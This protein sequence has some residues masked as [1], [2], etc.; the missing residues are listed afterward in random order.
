MESVVINKNTDKISKNSSKPATINREKTIP[1][2]V[3]IVLVT[4]F[5]AAFVRELPRRHKG[6]TAS[7]I[8]SSHPVLKNTCAK[9]LYPSL[10]FST[11]S[12]IPSSKNA[13]HPRHILV[14]AINLTFNSVNISQTHIMGLLTRQ[15]LNPQERN[16]L[17]DCLEMLDQTQYELQQA[18][19]LQD[20][21]YF[22]SASVGFHGRLYSNLKTLLSAAMTNENTCIDGFS[23]VEEA[24]PESQKGLKE[25]LHG[26]LAPIYRMISNC[27]A[28]VKLIESISRDDMVSTQKIQYPE[29]HPD[30]FPKWMTASDRKLT[31]VA[32]QIRPNLI[33]ATDGSGDY[34]TIGE[35]VRMAPRMSRSRFMIKIKTGVYKEN[36]EIPRS[37]TNIMLIGEGMNSTVISG[38]RNFVDGFS[39]FNSATLTVIGDRFLARDLT[40]INTSSREK[41]QAVALRVASNSA[42]YRC[43]F[44]SYQDTLYAHSF[45][46]LYRECTIQ[47]TIDFIFGNAA[48]IFQNCL[49]LV[50]KPIPGQKNMITA[51][52][53]DDPNQNTGISLQNC[54]IMAA[55]ELRSSYLGELI[56][57]QG[58]YQWDEYSRLDTVEYVEYMNTGPGSDTRRRVTWSGYKSNCSEEI[59]RRFTVGEFLHG[60]DDWLRSTGFPFFYG[61]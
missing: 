22:S 7:A 56:H 46:Q 52:G 41:R 38:S 48:A 59:V 44:I 1:L 17:Q 28:M 36:V 54:T 25:H 12:S 34:R 16:A 4:L 40:I 8:P 30:V 31:D 11:L 42:F 43:N 53:R 19:A 23:D 29:M 3:F 32:A 37:K 10:C 55:P 39:T 18:Q 57:P 51:Q 58:W 13:T 35:A 26:L 47:G 61:A 6:L 21:R 9:T 15:D 5:F 24:D 45:R 33:V 49:I 20:L 2:I 50:R 60:A 27:L 14:I